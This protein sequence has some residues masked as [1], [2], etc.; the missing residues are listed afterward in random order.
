MGKILNDNLAAALSWSDANA[1]AQLFLKAF[2]DTTDL[3]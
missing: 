2:F 1:G 3:R